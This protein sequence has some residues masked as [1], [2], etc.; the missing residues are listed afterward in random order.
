MTGCYASATPWGACAMPVLQRDDAG[1][2]FEECGRGSPVKLFAPGG[3]RS[4]L[5]IVP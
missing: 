1:T 2:Y 3:L 4:R 5:E